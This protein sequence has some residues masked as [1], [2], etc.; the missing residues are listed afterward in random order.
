MATNPLQVLKAL[1]QSVWLDYIDR[2]LVTDGELNRLITQDGVAGLTSNPAIFEH[3]IAQT[4]QYDDV[5]RTFNDTPVSAL[6][7][8]EA[9]ALNDVRTAADA[10]GGLYRASAG[11]DG[12]VSLEVSPH[13]AHDADASISEAR[14]LW[15][16]LD[17][18]NAMI[19]IPGTAAGLRAVRTLLTEGIN[20][21]VTLLFGVD[22]YREVVEAFMEG[23]EARAATGEAV[24]GVA[25]VASFFV[26]RID[27]YVDRRLDD[28]ATD[29]ARG[30]RGQTAVA[31]ARLAFQYFK[32]WTATE[33][34][35]RLAAKG[36]SPQRLLWASTSAKDPAY[37]DI[38]YVEALIGPDTVTTLPPATMDAYRRNG[39][40]ARRLED[41][42]PQAMSLP[43]ALERCDIRL[44]EVSEA[45]E[46]EGVRKFV[47]PFDKM[48]ASLS[49]RRKELEMSA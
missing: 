17:R 25:S 19:K 1:G 40:P 39:Q 41:D 5:I 38:K 10:F 11:K 2:R 18:P 23:L 15:G 9:I 27:T 29:V 4:S 7:L 24:A 43:E 47:E 20:V 6:S 14:R 44:K 13:L 30:L 28:L 21:N 22:R 8:Y 31:S 36:A 49:Q 33:R 37:S 46:R 35:Q 45:L 42:L 12:Y 26:S 16:A 32:Q 34:W 3:A 48:M